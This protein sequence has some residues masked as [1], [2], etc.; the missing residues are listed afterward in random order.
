MG[1]ITLS[2]LHDH[3][4]VGTFP[5]LFVLGDPDHV[6]VVALV[7]VNHPHRAALMDQGQLVVNALDGDRVPAHVNTALFALGEIIE[8]DRLLDAVDIDGDLLTTLIHHFHLHFH[9]FGQN[10][11][12]ANQNDQ[13][14]RNQIPC[15]RC[16]HALC[17]R[18]VVGCDRIAPGFGYLFSNPRASSTYGPP[19]AEI[20][21]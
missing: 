2:A 19:T 20:L 5:N 4:L 6:P 17:L 15:P 13:G 11:H 16:L 21:R 12:R 7:L 9:L 14:R 8:V 1:E 18:C 3:D 10:P